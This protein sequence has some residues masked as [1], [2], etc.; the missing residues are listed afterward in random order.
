MEEVRR[1]CT[2][3]RAESPGLRAA[4][5]GEEI[6]RDAQAAGEALRR[7]A[8]SRLDAAADLIVGRVVKD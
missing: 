3:Q 1:S 8:E 2:K 7:E 4:A 6:R 5:R